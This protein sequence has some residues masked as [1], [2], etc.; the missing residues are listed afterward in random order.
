MFFA[1]YIASVI[2]AIICTIIVLIALFKKQGVGLGILGIFCSPFTYIWGW[3]KSSELGLKKTMII[4][5][6]SLVC[7]GVFAGL[8]AKS[9]MDSP[10]MQKMIKDAQEQQARQ[11]QQQETAPAVPA[12]A[13]Q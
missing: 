9:V 11:I 3:L 8:A 13:P 2:V 6:L 5:T 12:P 1:L 7:A 4:W 10:E